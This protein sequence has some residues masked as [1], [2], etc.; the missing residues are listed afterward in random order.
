M[1]AVEPAAARRS[2][3]TP[4]RLA[5][6]L[7]AQRTWAG[8]RQ[9]REASDRLGELLRRPA[10]P[11][12]W[13]F[14]GWVYWPR[15]RPF[16]PLWPTGNGRRL[17]PLWLTTRSGRS[18]TSSGSQNRRSFNDSVRTGPSPARPRGPR[19]IGS[20]RSI[21]GWS[22]RKSARLGT[23]SRRSSSSSSARL[24]GGVPPKQTAPWRLGLPGPDSRRSGFP[25]AVF[26]FSD[27][28]SATKLV[29]PQVGG[30]AAGL[31][32][33]P[34]GRA[35]TEAGCTSTQLISRPQAGQGPNCSPS[36]AVI[37][38]LQTSSPS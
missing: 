18:A 12:N 2:R 27:R 17:W 23:I 4:T 24:V 5:V 37:R 35:P 16:A 30:V 9:L 20:S 14:T 22:A 29:H 13:R 31:G 28:L 3:R 15:S 26:E 21:K 11:A 7:S 8:R 6:C 36:L 10:A 1:S 32:Q 33:S 34:E 38:A 25:H 19:Q